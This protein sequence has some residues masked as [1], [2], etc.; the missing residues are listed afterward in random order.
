M[1]LL[2]VEIQLRLEE[3]R[4]EVEQ[5]G[6]ELVEILY[7]RA[8]QR[9]ILTFLVDKPQGITLEECAA[10]NQWLGA[11][12][13][14]L[15]EIAPSD[16]GFLQ[17]SY[18]LEVNSPGLDRPLKTPKDFQ[19]V[20]GQ[21]LRVQMRDTRGGISAVTG[22]LLGL[23]ETGIELELGGGARRSFG[24]EEVFKATREITWKK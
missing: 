14:R 10:I 4:A 2:P 9:G 5:G 8:S 22:R 13:D 15:A 19:R 6:A 21:P 3:I 11:Y 7:R 23:S 17:G 12:F 20:L 24:F 16:A 18:Y 1:M